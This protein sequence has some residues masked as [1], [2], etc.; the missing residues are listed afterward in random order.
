MSRSSVD[1]S[2]LEKEIHVLKG[3]NGYRR[4]HVD[5]TKGQE[6][7]MIREAKTTEPMF[8]RTR[9]S[10][11]E[12]DVEEEERQH[13]DDDDED[14]GKR[15]GRGDKEDDVL[16][17]IATKASTQP[18]VNDIRSVPNGGLWAWLQVLGSFF[19]FF[20]TCEFLHGKMSHEGGSCRCRND[21]ANAKGIL[22]L[23]RL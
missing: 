9:S 8:V 12:R 15:H 20:N 7:I 18:S 3:E 14:D 2:D 13:H 23:M 6:E 4:S 21:H 19:L 22:M 16:E 5:L 10:S 1:A 17:R 11:I